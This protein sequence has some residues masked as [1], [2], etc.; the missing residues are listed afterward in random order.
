MCFTHSLGRV[1]PAS[2]YLGP[3]EEARG[4]PDRS[5]VNGSRCC[6]LRSG[7]GEQT[8]TIPTAHRAH[9]GGVHGADVGVHLTPRNAALPPGHEEADPVDRRHVR[10]LPKQ[11][12]AENAANDGRQEMDGIGRVQ[13]KCRNRRSETVG[14][15]GIEPEGTAIS[16]GAVEQ[17]IGCP[18]ICPDRRGPYPSPRQPWWKG[19]LWLVFDRFPVVARANTRHASRRSSA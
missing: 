15:I 18:N 9:P 10:P 14:D 5:V 4:S 19:I 8:R 11:H 12:D 1:V 7:P 3:G 13:D 2:P 16:E 6:S 17:G